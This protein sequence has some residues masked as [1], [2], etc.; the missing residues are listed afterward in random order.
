MIDEINDIFILKRG[1]SKC[2][3]I[4]EIEDKRAALDSAAA[5]VQFS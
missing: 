2:Q 5:A 1:F 3:Q 4:I